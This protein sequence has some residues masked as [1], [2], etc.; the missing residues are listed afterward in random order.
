MRT[1]DL[2]QK[3]SELYN[4]IKEQLDKKGNDLL[5]DFCEVVRELTLREG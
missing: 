2:T 1:D 3:E 4:Q 5:S